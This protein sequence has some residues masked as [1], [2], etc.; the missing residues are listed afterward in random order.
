M[1]ATSPDEDIPWRDEKLIAV[2]IAPTEIM[3]QIIANPHKF[4]PV[5]TKTTGRCRVRL[6]KL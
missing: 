3:K 6:M 4:I 2:I 5:L 1:P